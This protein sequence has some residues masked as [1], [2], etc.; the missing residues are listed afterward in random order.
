MSKFYRTT[1]DCIKLNRIMWDF[2]Y[3]F[4]YYSNN[5]SSD[6]PALEIKDVT[7]P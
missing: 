7:T 5:K 4:F 1:W 2:K 6:N 3:K